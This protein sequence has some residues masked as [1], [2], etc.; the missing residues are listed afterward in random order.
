MNASGPPDFPASGA[1]NPYA[2]PAASIDAGG[3]PAASTR[4]YKSAR[5]LA[6]AITTVMGL[7]V[8]VEL[9]ADV[10]TCVTIGVMRRVLA[11]EAVS[12]AQLAAIDQ[13]AW[14]FWTASTALSLAATVLFC[15]FMPRANRNARAFGSPMN[16]TPGWAAGW[17]FVPIANLYKPYQ[18]MKEIW[19]GSDSDPNTPAVAPAAPGLLKWWWGMYLAENVAGGI[20]EMNKL[21]P[22]TSGFITLLSVELVC[23]AM[24]IAAAVLAAQV[25]RAVAA[26]QE[27][28]HLRAGAAP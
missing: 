28:R 24:S 27:A 14:A 5:P 1:V 19:Q 10:S 15:M 7:M 13:R 16:F 17:F 3:F 20:V 11:Q 2:A 25:V 4:G 21:A 12:Q 18:A 6:K 22:D 9:A 23:S 8:A 26:R